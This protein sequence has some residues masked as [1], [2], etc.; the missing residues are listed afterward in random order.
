[1][2]SSALAVT[3]A[4]MIAFRTGTGGLTARKTFSP[5][6]LRRAAWAGLQDSMPRAAG[7]SLHARVRDVPPDAWADPSLVQLWG[8]RFNVVVAALRDLAVFSL[9]VLPDGAKAR[10]RAVDVAARAADVVGTTFTPLGEAAQRM[11]VHHHLLRY[12]AATGT[13][14]IRWD[15]ARQPMI[16]VLPAPQVSPSAARHELARR[17]LHVY[18]PATPVSFGKWSGLGTRSAM[19]AFD[20]L[21]RDLIPVGTPI[22]NAWLQAADEAA[23]RARDEPAFVARVLPSGDPFLLLYGTD[24]AL[25]VP[26]GERAAALWPSRVWPGGLLVGGEIVGTWRRAGTKL[27]MQPWRRLTSA[28]RCML[29]DEAQCLPLPDGRTTVH[30]LT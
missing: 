23:L 16:R 27:Q 11:G 9:G 4:D 18:G 13:V 6:A 22:G 5:D 15:G 14:V 1:M 28:E 10:Q 7:L 29:A 12:A 2:S 19:V 3:R 26:D 17:Y 24:R 21:R 25:L 30:W 20:E 8:P